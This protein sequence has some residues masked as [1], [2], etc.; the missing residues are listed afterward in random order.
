MRMK[1][2][3]PSRQQRTVA[4]QLAAL[5]ELI[6]REHGSRGLDISLQWE[7]ASKH[8]EYGLMEFDVMWRDFDA[9]HEEQMRLATS[10]DHRRLLMNSWMAMHGTIMV[11]RALFTARMVADLEEI[12]ARAWA[13]LSP[14]NFVL[15]ELAIAESTAAFRASEEQRLGLGHD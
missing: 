3:A 15:L 13:L 9:T 11:E 2:A 5:F 4:K 7:S 6:S 10:A 8:L 12:R 14:T 1:K